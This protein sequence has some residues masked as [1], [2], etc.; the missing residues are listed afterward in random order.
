VKALAVIPA[1]GG[2]KGLPRKNVRPLCG[3][4]LIAWTIEAAR[5]AESVGRV[6]VSTDDPEIASVSRRFGAEVVDRPK[7]LSCDEASSESAL[8]HALEA[9][10]VRSG[11]LVF[12]QCTSPLTLPDDIDGTVRALENA[13]SAF[14]AA[15]SH[16]FLWNRVGLLAQPVGHDK[17]HRKRR[18]ELEP[19]YVEAGS[20]YAVS[21]PAFIKERT[22][23]A[24][25]T[26]LYPIP[27]ERAIEIDDATDFAIAEALM[28]LR[29]DR[30]RASLLPRPLKAVVMDFDGV[31]TDNR[32]W[33]DESGEEQVACHRGDGW[34]IAR[35][36]ELGIRLLVLTSESNPSVARRCEKL[37]VERLV[38]PG[39]K[40]PAFE[41]WLARTGV[42]PQSAVY[43]GN[44]E[45]DAP[46][47]LYA[48]CG[49][50]PQDAACQAK[51]A[52]RIVLD[53]P[54]GR[55]CVRELYQLIIEN[56][57]QG[58]PK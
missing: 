22:R 25:R 31:L 35:M 27:A 41:A 28:R 36:R 48:G 10:D 13:E 5:A 34:A 6:V 39:S 52:A 37:G 4:P 43:V 15:P 47:M 57:R 9:L 56:Y 24:G 14:A 46:C 16:R 58:G 19:Q 32:V 45:P 42:A 17:T 44:D 51:S 21:I 8:L 23:F 29:L 49:I 12:L 38:A 18:Q 50:A 2:S 54:G 20:V 26:A 40:L 53:T 30:D 7:E 55:G 11:I 33:V 1:R 3:K